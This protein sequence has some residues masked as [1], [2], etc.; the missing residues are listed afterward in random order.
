MLQAYVTS[1]VD[2]SND[3]QEINQTVQQYF[4][5]QYNS[6]PEVSSGGILSGWLEDIRALELQSSI[7]QNLEIM[8][9]WKTIELEIPIIC[10]RHYSFS[11][12]IAIQNGNILWLD[13]HVDN[14]DFSTY[15][16]ES[17]LINQLSHEAKTYAQCVLDLKLNYLVQPYLIERIDD[18]PVSESLQSKRLKH[19]TKH[20]LK[21]L[22]ERFHPPLLAGNTNNFQLDFIVWTHLRGNVYVIHCDWDGSQFHYLGERLESEIGDYVMFQ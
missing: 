10:A 16:V 19:E 22:K 8:T 14:R 1:C 11:A 18:L 9:V 17:R 15:L 2:M 5:H 3:L 20:K 7:A 6:T 12:M 13:N 21:N 4:A